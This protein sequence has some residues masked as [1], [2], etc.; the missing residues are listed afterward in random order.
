M[1]FPGGSGFESEKC[2]IAFE[3]VQNSICF[4]GTS[5]QPTTASKA[6]VLVLHGFDIRKTVANFYEDRRRRGFSH[7]LCIQRDRNFP[8]QKIPQTGEDNGRA[9]N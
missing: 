8:I 6:G 7:F 2:S 9:W 1:Y 5:A 4:K 3:T